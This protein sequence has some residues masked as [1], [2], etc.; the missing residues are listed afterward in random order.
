MAELRQFFPWEGVWFHWEPYG[1]KG[2]PWA[3]ICT[4][5][6]KNWSRNG[7]ATAIFPLRGCVIPF[8]TTWDKRR[9]LGAHLY[10]KYPKSVKKWLRYGYFPVGR[11]GDS[12]E[13][14]MGQKGILG[15]FF[16]P[17]ISKISQQMAGLGLFIT[18]A[19]DKGRSCVHSYQKF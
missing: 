2:D 10:H 11:L 16:V 1:K 5:K 13:N 14:H 19:W 7:W 6:I 4:E 9:Y 18:W 12:I 3:L 8:R 15:L 17:K